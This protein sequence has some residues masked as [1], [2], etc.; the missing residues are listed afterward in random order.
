MF[1]GG[2]EGI[3]NQK[4]IENLKKG[5]LG[6]KKVNVLKN[7]STEKKLSK[8]FGQTQHNPLINTGRS[9]LNIIKILKN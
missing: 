6:F 4:K 1:I 9:Q 7:F 2:Y 8:K 5:Y 3:N